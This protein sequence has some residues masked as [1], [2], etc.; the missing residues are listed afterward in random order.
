MDFLKVVHGLGSEFG[1][2]DILKCGW[3][4]REP[5]VK[6]VNCLLTPNPLYVSTEAG[7][8]AFFFFFFFAN[9]F[10]A[11]K[12]PINRSGRPKP[13]PKPRPSRRLLEFSEPDAS[14][15][16]IGPFCLEDSGFD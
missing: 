3:T 13:K 10:H 14:Q 16:N 12:R 4:R 1:T 6:Y 15:M 9:S 7:F 8:D 11:T 5:F 2:R